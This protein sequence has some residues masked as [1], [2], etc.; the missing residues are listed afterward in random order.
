[1]IFYY[2]SHLACKEKVC[3]GEIVFTIECDHI[4]FADGAFK[5]AHGYE[6]EKLSHIA[7]TKDAWCAG[8]VKAHYSVA[9]AD[10]V[11]ALI[12]PPQKNKKV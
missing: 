9:P 2:V 1:M 6:P 8:G 7:V 11:A 10:K 3:A 4:R 12:A 5:T